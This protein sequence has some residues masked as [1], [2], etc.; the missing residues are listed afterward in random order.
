MSN[1]IYV[2]NLGLDIKVEDL[3]Q[4]FIAIGNVLSAR[5]V[6]DFYTGKS[7]GFGFVEME[8]HS[9]VIKAVTEL[10]GKEFHG[11]QIAVNTAG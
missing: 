2:G 3:K 1:R 7:K 8:N 11:R 10:N 9:D 4:L 6:K 5:I